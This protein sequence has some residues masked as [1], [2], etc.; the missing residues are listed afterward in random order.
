MVP[1]IE[2]LR[3]TDL[4]HPIHCAAEPSNAALAEFVDVEREKDNRLE[5][6][7]QTTVEHFTCQQS[8]MWDVDGVLLCKATS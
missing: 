3:T 6:S 1:G 8:D 4:E 2:S 5:S 7:D